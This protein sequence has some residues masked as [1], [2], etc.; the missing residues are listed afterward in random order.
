MKLEFWTQGPNSWDSVCQV[1]PPAPKRQIKRHGEGRERRLITYCGKRQSKQSAHLQPSSKVQTWVTGLNRERTRG[2]GQKVC[3]VKQF[4]HRCGLFDHCL[5]L[6][7]G[8]SSRRGSGRW[9]SWGKSTVGGRCYHL[10]FLESKVIAKWLQ[11]EWLRAKT[12]TKM[13]DSCHAFSC[14]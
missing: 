12:D 13:E 4:S 11:R 3:I 7:S 6:C 9:P 5:S 2:R 10:S 1:W 14:Y 8:R